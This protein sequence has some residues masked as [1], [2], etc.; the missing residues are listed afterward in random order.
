MTEDT[1]EDWL[2]QKR[3]KQMIMAAVAALVVA[4]GVGAL[5]SFGLKT[6]GELLEQ[7]AFGNDGT[8]DWQVTAPAT[9]IAGLWLTCTVNAPTKRGPQDNKAVPVY[10]LNGTLRVQSGQT[11][12][13]DGPL[14][15]ADDQGP[16]RAGGSLFSFGSTTCA[17]N[18]RRCDVER[19][20]RLNGL[21]LPPG[22]PAQV[23]GSMPTTGDGLRVEGCALQLRWREG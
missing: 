21:E 2:V 23:T 18:G 8:M 5:V 10:S 9:G 22:Q 15:F 11:T 17:D 7:T 19:T 3:R 12:I 13:Y 20:V 14:N 4:G 16:V 6:Q 1:G